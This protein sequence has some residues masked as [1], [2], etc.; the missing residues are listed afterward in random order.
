MF[1]R[2]ARDRML[3]PFPPAKLEV[4]EVPRGALVIAG[5]GR[6]PAEVTGRFI[7]LAGGP[8]A[9]II[10]L[11]TA[12]PEAAQSR[13]RD[14][15]F[16]AEA[17]AKNVRVLEARRR[18]E[19]EST[20]FLNA[21]KQAKGIW[22]AGGRQ[23]RF[24]DAY[25]GTKAIDGFRE[26]LERGGVIGGSSAG[27]TIQGEYLVRGSPLGNQEMMAEGYERGFAFLT[28]T[29]IDQHFAQRNR[30]VDM[31]AVVAAHP[32]LLGIG[33]D[34]STAIVVRGHVAE[35]FGAHHAHFYDQSQPAADN[36]P[37]HTSLG[38]GA[39]YDLKARRA[40]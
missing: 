3:P 40:E 22:F 38:A 30:F 10:V 34:E 37:D 17:G 32:Q 15:E 2:A 28:G 25:E 9:P 8:D 13:S 1:R 4:P 27:A 33:L 7:E 20:E 12:M 39:R 6:L 36:V 14:G 21:L 18:E 31:A 11:P 35:V 29:A 23:W 19:V 5:G 16:L 24:V 26:V